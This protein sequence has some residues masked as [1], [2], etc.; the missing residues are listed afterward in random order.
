MQFYIVDEDP[1]VNIEVLP[2]Y[3]LKKV[4]VR[5]GWQILSDIGHIMGV[6]WHGQNKAYSLSH[7]L[8]RSHCQNRVRFLRFVAHYEACVLAV[9]GSFLD[10]FKEAPI[11][12][13]ASAI[14]EERD[15]CH[16]QAEYILNHKEQHLNLEEFTKLLRHILKKGESYGN[17]E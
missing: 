8:T 17:G 16:F 12:E 2:T 11:G 13:I 15:E 5:E 9:G 4:N 3:A 6:S 1:H 14:P 10:K 7:V